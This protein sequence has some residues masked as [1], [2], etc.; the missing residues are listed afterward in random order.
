MTG[1]QGSVERW[2]RFRHLPTVIAVPAFIVG[3]KN[4]GKKFQLFAMVQRQRTPLIA[5]EQDH[6]FDV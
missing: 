4:N 1:K 5:V 3:F 2:A 6:H